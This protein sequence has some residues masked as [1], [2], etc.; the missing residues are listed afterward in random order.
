MEVE[1]VRPR[2]RPKKTWKHCVEEDIREMIIW[3]KLFTTEKE[4]E[5]LISRPTP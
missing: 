2:G 1:G 3:K 4:W 5:K